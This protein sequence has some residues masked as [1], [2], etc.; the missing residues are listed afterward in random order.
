M[1]RAALVFGLGDHLTHGLQHLHALVADDEFYA[2]QAA[3]AELWKKL[4]Q[5]A[6]EVFDDIQ[7]KEKLER[8]DLE[9]IIHRIKVYEDHIEIKLKE[10]IGALLRCGALPQEDAANFNADFK[11]ISLR[12]IV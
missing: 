3:S 5:L 8:N 6:L 1:Y 4:T 11:D 12:R 2:V 9:L 10:D 7:N